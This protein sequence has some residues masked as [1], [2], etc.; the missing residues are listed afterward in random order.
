MTGAA[1]LAS[2]FDRP[3][4]FDLAQYWARA[5]A[6]LEGKRKRFSV[7]LALAPGAAQM[8][9]ARC[10]MSPVELSASA[11][12]V[13]EGW[14]TVRAEFDDEAFARFVVLGLGRRAQAIEPAD[15]RR[16]IHE[17]AGQV[18]AQAS[19]SPEKNSSATA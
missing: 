11:G 18:A 13:P 6:E 2:G 15:F 8:L 17:E 1:A 3:P 10:P 7:T 5:T 12:P 16:S 14:L 9:T 19:R 4:K